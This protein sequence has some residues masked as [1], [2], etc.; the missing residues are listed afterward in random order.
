MIFP[1]LGKWYKVWEDSC[2]LIPQLYLPLCN[3]MDYS[4]AGSSVQGISQARILEWVAISSSR[5]S[6]SPRDWTCISTSSALQVDSLMLRHWG[7]KN[8]YLFVINCTQVVLCF[9][10]FSSDLSNFL[11]MNIFIRIHLKRLSVARKFS[12]K[13]GGIGFFRTLL[14]DL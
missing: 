14:R 9:F 2:C 1:V 5:E 8:S 6:S 7:S 3:H 4:M 10:R 11:T 13:Q 12:S